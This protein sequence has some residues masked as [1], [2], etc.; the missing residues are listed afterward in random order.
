MTQIAEEKTYTQDEL[1]QLW[2]KL[3]D[4]PVNE[5]EEIDEPFHLWEAGTPR[6]E[7]WQWFDQRFD[8]GLYFH[9]FGGK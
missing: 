1:S 6:E 5:E 7:V 8:H 3:G 2:T 9:M 4:T